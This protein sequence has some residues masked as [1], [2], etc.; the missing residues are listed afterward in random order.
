MCK[1][2]PLPLAPGSGPGRPGQVTSSNSRTG[3]APRSP[4][5]RS[6][7]L[8]AVGHTRSRVKRKVA[9]HYKRPDSNVRPQRRLSAIAPNSLQWRKQLQK[10]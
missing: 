2:L 10:K 7:A 9:C 1:T 5:I 3:R 8:P 4:R 6:A